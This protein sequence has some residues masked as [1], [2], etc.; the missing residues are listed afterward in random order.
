MGYIKKIQ[1]E[2]IMTKK[3]KMIMIHFLLIDGRRR[4]CVDY[5]DEYGLYDFW[6]DYLEYLKAQY[7]QHLLVIEYFSDMTISYFRIKNR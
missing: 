5:I 2:V 6:N 4:E 3:D 1:T 7:C